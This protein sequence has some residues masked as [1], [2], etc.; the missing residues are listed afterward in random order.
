MPF[1]SHIT[2]RHNHIQNIE[3]N[4]RSK[5]VELDLSENHFNSLNWSNFDGLNRLRLLNLSSNFIRHLTRGSKN[6]ID[7]QELDLSRN[8][9]AVID[10]GDLSAFL[11]LNRLHLNYLKRLE[12]V[13]LEGLIELRYL[14]LTN[15]PL[16]AHINPTSFDGLNSLETLDLR[17][18][19]LTSMTR[20]LVE[21]LSTLA[22]LQ[23]AGNKW[24]CDCEMTWIN[25][26]NFLIDDAKCSRPRHYASL[27]LTESTGNLTCSEPVI[28]E[29][30]IVAKKAIG[31][32]VILECLVTGTPRPNV[33]WISN[34]GRHMM[35]REDPQTSHSPN[36]WHKATYYASHLDDIEERVKVLKNG[37]LLI[38]Y[39]LRTDAGIY[40]CQAGNASAAVRFRLDFSI[41]GRI[42]LYTCLIGLLTAVGM[43]VLALVIS[44]IK[45]LA[46]LCSKEQ[47]QKRKSVKQILTSLGTYKS[48]KFDQL[49]AYKTAKIDALN[50]YKTRKVSKMKTYKKATFGTM[51][52]QTTR[53]R[54]YYHEQV[55]RIREQ[56][57]Q[58]SLKLRE[59]YKNMD[60]AG[61]LREQYTCQLSKVRDYSSE[62]LSKLHAQ[63]KIQQQHLIKLMELLN[64]TSCKSAIEAEC[65]RTESLLFDFDLDF[66]QHAVH[67]PPMKM[68]ELDEADAESLM[69]NSDPSPHPKRK[70]LHKKRHLTDEHSD[71]EDD[72]LVENYGPKEDDGSHLNNES[73]LRKKRRQK[74]HRT[75]VVVEIGNYG[76]RQEEDEELPCCS[77]KV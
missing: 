50:K 58:Q 41:I 77:D 12:R 47:R 25:D 6:L 69:M 21:N 29:H 15:C 34:R 8:S 74:Q 32:S 17:R 39:V 23:L 14:S 35:Y 2:L 44:I 60:Y 72:I 1:A 59:S 73:R 3:C 13:S 19:A 36:I 5:L 43:G 38:E 9:F 55:N 22:S 61:R 40:Y 42:E 54:V 51:Y 66:D 67:V 45:Y 75:S 76:T 70:R 57:L 7:L 11:N 33:T 4:N 18:N 27:N 16:L 56:C 46:W 30:T 53:M 71:D 68:D 62:Q 24:I 63:Y 20:K 31:K 37:S 26:V 65:L 52:A 64:M 49:H 48:A 10:G 28:L